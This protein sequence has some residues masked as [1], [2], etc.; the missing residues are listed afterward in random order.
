MDFIPNYIYKSSFGEISNSK[1]KIVKYNNFYLVSI[2]NSINL[3]NFKTNELLHSFR[4]KKYSVTF[5]IVD[6]K[7]LIIGYSSGLI[8]IYNLDTFEKYL[9]YKIHTKRI[10]K[11]IKE[12]DYV[13]SSASDGLLIKYDLIGEK[14][15]KIVSLNSIDTFCI[16]KNLYGISC[17]N[18]TFT[19]LVD[20]HEHTI[21][22]PYRIKYL[23]PITNKKILFVF[24]NNEIKVYDICKNDYKDITK[25]KKIRQVKVVEN[26]LFILNEKKIYKFDLL[27]N[28]ELVKINKNIGKDVV[29]FIS[30]DI[31]ISRN[32]SYI[33]NKHEFSYHKSEILKIF[34]DKNLRICTFSNDSLII[35]N[36]ESKFTIY[37]KIELSD[38]KCCC[39]FNNWYVIGTS[40]CVLFY[41]IHSL[42]VYKI[43]NFGN[44]EKCNICVDSNIHLGIAFNKILSVYNSNLEI[45]D[46]FQ[47]QDYISCLKITKKNI[48]IGLINSKIYIY[49]Y[50]KDLLKTLYGHSLPVINIQVHNNLIYTVGLD[51]M[52]KIWGIEF[53]DCRKSIIVNDAKNIKIFD[54][55]F[56]VPSGTLKYY[57]GFKLY[58]EKKYTNCNYIYQTENYMFISNNINVSIYEIDKYELELID[59]EDDVSEIIEQNYENVIHID[60]F[61]NFINYLDS[62]V[63]NFST[64]LYKLDNEEINTF[65]FLLNIQQVNNLIN[66]L[67]KIKYSIIKFR[68]IKSL[69]NAH[70]EIVCKNQLFLDERKKLIEKIY[71]LR[72]KI[73]RNIQKLKLKTGIYN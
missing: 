59:H 73:G 54:S 5:F 44:E 62:D 7:N 30:D 17:T 72:N 36:I 32:N 68:L 19:Y 24:F 22:I 20:D 34:Q 3:W 65:I 55:L 25:F 43:I 15:E 29:D 47:L 71:K 45:I 37:N 13:F 49:N 48:I 53:G 26:F 8:K 63:G 38:G 28:F 56:L 66:K 42:K 31:F 12:S 6:D 70:Q 67:S 69:Y 21:S 23:H 27:K 51:K 9:E 16:F 4:N 64:F 52:L 14:Y 50:E 33:I 2:E 1:S 57:K 39:E 58:Y 60:K 46:K 18:S 41:D 61:D 40:N 10:T 11:I 35:W